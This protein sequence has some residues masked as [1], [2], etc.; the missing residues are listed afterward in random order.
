MMVNMA[1]IL[2]LFICQNNVGEQCGMLND[3]KTKYTVRSRSGFTRA[4]VWEKLRKS[5]RC[6]RPCN[7]PKNS[8]RAKVHAC[9]ALYCPPIDSPDKILIHC[10]TS[11]D[12][13][14]LGIAL[15][16]RLQPE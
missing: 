10:D 9:L 12:C 4:A 16:G 6:H 2:K 7:S 8:K 11:V 1:N 5:D 15:C 14:F 13:E 3:G